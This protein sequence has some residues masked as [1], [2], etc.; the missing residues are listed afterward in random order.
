VADS[1]DW[2][3]RPDS[4][5]FS[6]RYDYSS[7]ARPLQALYIDFVDE[8][9]NALTDTSPDDIGDFPLRFPGT[10]WYTYI[11]SGDYNA[12]SVT[13]YGTITSVRAVSAVPEPSGFVLMLLGLCA[14]SFARHWRK[15]RSCAS[16]LRRS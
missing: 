8:S 15:A 16:A 9:A 6:A 5:Q 4:V 3:S 2:T 14:G 13:A 7:L 11:E 1:Q 10:F 12:R